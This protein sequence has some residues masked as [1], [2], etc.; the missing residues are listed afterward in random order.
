LEDTLTTILATLG[1]TTAVIGIVGALAKFFGEQWAK[2]ILEKDR[3]MYA[4]EI[5]KLRDQLQFATQMTLK[6]RDHFFNLSVTSH[7][8]TVAFDKH[9][10]FCEEYVA[11][12]Y[13]AVKE[14]FRDGP[15]QN[16]M[17]VAHDLGTIRQRYAPWVTADILKNLKPFEDAIFRIGTRH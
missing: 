7:M 9:V 13:S 2:K 1:R 5:E 11:Q 6:Q 16:A 17:K 15:S 10:A 3:H 12:A 8:A 14:L 4:T